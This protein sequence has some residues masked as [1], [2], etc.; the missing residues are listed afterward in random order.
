MHACLEEYAR[1]IT[2]LG[3]KEVHS[4]T[5]LVSLMAR[6][7]SISLPGE[8]QRVVYNG[9]KRVHALEFQSVTIFMVQVQLRA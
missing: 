8:K 5:V 3:A 9:H 4:P 2:S 7:R 6:V 1:A